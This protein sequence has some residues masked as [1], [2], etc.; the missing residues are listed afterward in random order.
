MNAHAL[1]APSLAFTEHV[2]MLRAAGWS[3]MRIAR[4]LGCSSS[5]LR[6]RV[7]PAY[8]ARRRRLWAALNDRRRADRALARSTTLSGR[9]PTTPTP[10]T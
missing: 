7:D 10:T 2:Q 8:K 6:C 1:P 4:A 5:H 9:Q 3:W